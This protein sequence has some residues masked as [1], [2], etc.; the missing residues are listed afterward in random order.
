MPGIV[1]KCGQVPGIPGIGQQVQI[2]DAPVR[3]VAAQKMDKIGADE[4]RAAG[5]QN[6][7]HSCPPQASQNSR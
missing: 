3:A 2:E 1:R 4:S 6:Y 7:A 5:D